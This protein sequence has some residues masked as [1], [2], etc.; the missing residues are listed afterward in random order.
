MVAVTWLPQHLDR[1][2]AYLSN[3][4]LVMKITSTP[5][6]FQ[7]SYSYKLP[8]LTQLCLGM[9]TAN[10]NAPSVDARYVQN[11]TINIVHNTG[12]S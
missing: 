1:T 7:F 12:M 11:L 4:A 8:I 2:D 5:T 3:K 6:Y 10:S 9:P